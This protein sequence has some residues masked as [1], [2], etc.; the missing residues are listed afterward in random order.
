MT[1]RVTSRLRRGSLTC[2]SRLSAAGREKKVWRG[3]GCLRGLA[4]AGG[5]WAG[6]TRAGSAAAF[7]FFF[8]KS[9]L[10]FKNQNKDNFCLK[11]P[12]EFKPLS[13]KLYNQN[14]PN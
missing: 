2:G 14:T 3:A 7:L 6:P 10:F 8:D 5:C 13:K 1:S 4:R 9:F 11:T 12:N